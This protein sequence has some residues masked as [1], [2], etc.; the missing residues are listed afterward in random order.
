MQYQPCISKSAIRMIIDN[1]WHD[2]L[3]HARPIHLVD[4]IKDT[5]Y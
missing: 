4:N 3:A 2:E 1:L 5:Y